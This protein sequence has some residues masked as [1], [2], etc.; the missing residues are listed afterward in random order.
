MIDLK[1]IEKI[2]RT[3]HHNQKRKDG[4]AY[5]E[6]PVAVSK[7]VN[8]NVSKAVALLHD[9]IEDCH[10]T[11]K[12][13]ID[14]GVDQ[15][16]AKIVD[17]VSRKKSET[18]STFIQRIIK[19]KNRIACDVKIADLKHNLSDLPKDDSLHHR[20]T[21]ALHL[22]MNHRLKLNHLKNLEGCRK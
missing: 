21:E 16:V 14:I 6:H 7:L 4:S 18:Y 2:A 22:L 5:I 10:I 12:G 3:L 17:I 20:Y 8:G 13:L 1:F 11:V 15:E 19:S 9:V